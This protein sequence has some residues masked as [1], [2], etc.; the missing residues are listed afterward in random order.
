MVTNITGFDEATEYVGIWNNDTWD[1]TNATWT[2]YNGDGS[3]NDFT[4]HTFDVIQVYLTDSGTQDITTYDNSDMNYDSFSR[5]YTLTNSSINKGYNFSAYVGD[6]DTTLSAIN[7]S[8][9]LDAGE[10]CAVWNNSTYTWT[11]YIAFFDIKDDNVQ[12]WNVVQTK[13]EDM[14]TWIT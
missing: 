7:N 3:G 11:W 4:V 1:D 8:I 5:T 2:R 9:G 12:K 10:G 6:A 13:V 14:E